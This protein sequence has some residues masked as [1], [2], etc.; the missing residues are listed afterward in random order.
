[1]L[2]WSIETCVSKLYLYCI[3]FYLFIVILCAKMSRVTKALSYLS[4]PVAGLPVQIKDESSW[5]SRFHFTKQ[6]LRQVFK[7]ANPFYMGIS[8]F[9]YL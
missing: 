7:K 1:M 3:S 2:L 6:L 5:T 8:L 4:C 9:S